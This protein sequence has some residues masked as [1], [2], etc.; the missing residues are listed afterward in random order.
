[1]Q[2]LLTVIIIASVFYPYAIIA[3]SILLIS[4]M[5]CRSRRKVAKL[6]QY[7]RRKEPSNL[8]SILRIVTFVCVILLFFRPK[9]ILCVCARVCLAAIKQRRTGILRGVNES[10][11]RKKMPESARWRHTFLTLW[12]TFSIGLVHCISSLAS[13]KTFSFPFCTYQIIMYVCV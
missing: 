7:E 13:V 11:I 9:L 8:L 5:S 6:R 1:M 3:L 10:K 2:K 12:T 4:C